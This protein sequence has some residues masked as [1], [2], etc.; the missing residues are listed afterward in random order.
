[1]E[2]GRSRSES[3]GDKISDEIYARPEVEAGA[4]LGAHLKGKTVSVSTLT[5][6]T[7]LM[8]H[9]VLEKGY[10]LKQKDYRLLVVDTSPQRYAALEGASEGPSFMGPPFTFH[11][12]KDGFRKL[13]NF[14]AR[15]GATR[16]RR[17]HRQAT[18]R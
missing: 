7:T 3:L 4:N 5:G 2:A 17:L 14:H 8:V 18:T 11:A 12:A 15:E 6:G 1:M 10:K 9:E 16:A 13:A